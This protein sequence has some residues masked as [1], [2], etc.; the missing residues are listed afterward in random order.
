MSDSTIPAFVDVLVVGAGNAALC[1]AISAA[2]QGAK[3]L[4]LERSP[5]EVRGGNSAYT[6]GAFRVAYEGA[7][8][9]CRLVP[10]LSEDER[11]RSDFGTY[12]KS[13][14]F[15]ELIEMSG[16]RANADLVEILVNQSFETLQWMRTQGVRF[17]PIHGRQSFVVDGKNKFWGGLTVEVSGGGAGLVESLFRRAQ[18]LGV[19]VAYDH[20]MTELIMDNGRVCGVVA[21]HKG[22]E[23]RLRAGAVVLAAG[24]FH[25]N[26]EWR[27][28]Y[29]GVNWDLAKVRGSRYN[30]GLAIQAALDKG[31]RAAG[32]WTAC[33]SVFYDANAPEFGQPNLLNQQKNYFNLGVVVNTLGERFVDEGEN[34]RNYTYSRMGAVI[35]KQPDARGW[36]IFDAVGAKLLPDEYRV[37]HATRFQA[38]TLEGLVAQ[39]E[40]VD[41]KRLLA[42]L[43]EFNAAVDR[44]VPF[45]PAV[46]DGRSTKGLAINKSNWALPLEQGPFVAFEVSCGITCTY[47]G[48]AITSKSE[49][50]DEEGFPMPGLYAAGEMVGGLFF[51]KYPGGAGLT[52]GSVFGRIAGQEAARLASA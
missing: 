9:I 18:R 44:S 32:H 22:Q 31:A 6:G 33:H 27:A 29:L 46:L 25:A 7:E 17:I 2:E 28:R 13:Q 3:V 36:Q 45:N 1:A 51:T 52:A 8:D 20:K 11:S 40:G 42:T 38:D 5:E 49:V 26:A 48:L 16:M 14:Y 12:S 37:R 19:E 10:D 24:G 41:Q 4:V 35:L 43:G 34:F 21:M 47:A 23:I 15:D 50:L 39:F 30:T